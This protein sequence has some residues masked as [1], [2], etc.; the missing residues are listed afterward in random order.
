MPASRKP[1]KKR[2]QSA[3]KRKASA[4]NIVVFPNAKMP[5]VMEGLLGARFRDDPLD[6]A[7]DLVYD[8]WDCADPK[9]RI[10]LAQKALSISPLCVDAYNL[11]A[12]EQAATPEEV[13][14]YYQ[15][16]VAVGQAA[17]GAEGFKAY[18]GHFWGFLETRPYMRARAGLGEALWAMG[19]K[20][21]AIQNFRE[22]LELNP[23]DNQGIRY[24]LVAKLLDMGQMDDL[25]SLLDHCAEEFCADIQYTRALVAY[26]EGAENAAEIAKI[27]WETNR[28]VPGMLSGRRP[29]IDLHGYITL[30]GQDEASSYVAAFGDAWQR[31]PGAINWIEQLAAQLA[32]K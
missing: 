32:S 15:K 16:A 3:V 12:E 2:K 22:M 7:Q 5:P 27:A 23:G 30:G 13:L 14:K 9:Q 20:S 25:K 26:W 28:Y 4:D 21:G 18:A 1:P 6:Q 10:A 11:L 24:V 8:A 29:T 17:L 19:D 31:T